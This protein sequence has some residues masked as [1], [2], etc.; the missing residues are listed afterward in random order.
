MER[1]EEGGILAEL[2]LFM[3]R[4]REEEMKQMEAM[5]QVGGGEGVGER[6]DEG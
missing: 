5:E 6:C 1:G 3:E 4:M 2:D